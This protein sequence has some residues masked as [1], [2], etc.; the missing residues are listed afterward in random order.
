MGARK[1]LKIVRRGDLNP[2]NLAIASTSS[3]PSTSIPLDHTHLR[4]VGGGVIEWDRVPYLAQTRH[5]TAGSP[6]F[7]WLPLLAQRA[8]RPGFPGRVRS[9]DARHIG[10]AAGSSK[11]G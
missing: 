11:S 1:L 10:R 8:S 9:G 3:Y 4:A 7:G 2:H 6:R 5:K